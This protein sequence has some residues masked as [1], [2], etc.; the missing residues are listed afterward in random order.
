MSKILIVSDIHID[1]Y[2]QRN[3]SEKYRLRQ[4][5]VV[6]R[7]IIEAAQKEGAELIAIAGDVIEKSVI[8]PYVQTE[9]KLFLDTLMSYF[10]GGWIIWGNHDLDTRNDNQEAGDSVLSVMLPPNLIYADKKEYTIDGTRIGF[11]NFRY[12]EFDLSWINGKLD[13]LITHATINYS[14]DEDAFQGKCSVL[15][16]SK[17]DLAISGDIHQPGN[18]GKFVSIGVPQK[19][20]MGDNDRS[21]G[22]IYD[23]VLRSWKHIDLD[24]HGRL[25]KFQYTPDREKEGWD[26]ISSTWYIYRSESGSTG[27]KVGNINV[28]AWEEVN[29]LID[30]IITT[31]GLNSIHS[32]VN[33]NCTDIDSSMVDFMFTLKSLKCKNWRSIEE[34]ELYFDS[35][36][37]I[38]ITGK[39]GSGKSSFLSALKYAFL[40]NTSYKDFIQFGAKECWTEVG[41]DYQGNQYKLRRG[42]GRTQGKDYGLWM[43]GELVDYSGKQQFTT[44]IPVRFPFLDY[45]DTFFFDSDH[46]K[47][48][49]SL[50]EE[51]KSSLISKFFK[52][53]KID[54]LHRT[55][56]IL[57]DRSDQDTKE[58][59]REI[60]QTKSNL[61]IILDSIGNITLPS[62]TPKEIRDEKRD[63]ELQE[64]RAREWQ[65]Y[66]NSWN[67]LIFKKQQ[68]E[69]NLVNLNSTPPLDLVNLREKFRLA[70]SEKQ[71]I[72]TNQIPRLLSIDREYSSLQSELQR[73][74]TEGLRLKSELE[75]LGTQGICSHCNQVLSDQT[76]FENH[77]QSLTSRLGK[78]REEYTRVN[79]ELQTLKERRDKS[80]EE[81][82]RLQ[83]RVNSLDS[84]M[85][86]LSRQINME[87]QRIKTISQ[88]KQELAVI[89]EKMSI[90]KVPVKVEIPSDFS[91]IYSQL[92]LDLKTWDDYNK[93][94]DEKTSYENSIK[95]LEDKIKLASVSMDDI[96][97]YLKVTSPTG[98]IYEEI[99][100]KLADQFSDNLV[101]YSVSKYKT[102]RAGVITEH[103]DLSLYFMNKGNP[104][105]YQAASS[106]QQ[107][108]MDVH[109]MSKVITGLGLVVM[110]E[111]LKHLDS[112]NHDVC[113]DMIR[114]MNLGCIL[115]SSHMEGISKF[116]NKSLQMVLNDSGS[117]IITYS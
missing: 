72:S 37:K 84:E 95:D 83:D 31:S 16:E 65:E 44:D 14:Q 35:G 99:M 103:L 53:D 75:N 48:I 5:R 28:P 59:R 42:S 46:P 92:T 4:S 101:K 30:S 98:K 97:N 18:K 50:G 47:L 25:M 79:G 74:T 67:Q 86:E 38:L 91:Q 112:K 13:L 115:L 36:D 54:A 27:V 56:K 66:I 116:N 108:T 3:P 110:D 68:C 40:G 43:N 94:I 85:M 20:K 78:S 10:E 107:T 2:A 24:P 11:Y 113:I 45:F 109:F 34:A 1:D 64:R 89:E 70:G 61:K 102:T 57:Y 80:N 93:L 81:I 33:Q 69:E 106:G 62:K 52:L 60:N 49:G 12:G 15:D 19:C 7:N 39:N 32:T 87:E 104:V 55:A 96:G 71:D 9:V 41:F 100:K 105:A 22:V 17:F 26:P 114:D 58:W 76:V 77:K 29:T 88:V 117:T 90:T 21:T 63:M 8:R 73:I 111:F 6:A 82:K 23:T 51:K